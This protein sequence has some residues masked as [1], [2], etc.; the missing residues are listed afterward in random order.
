[1]KLKVTSSYCRIHFQI[2]FFSFCLQLPKPAR[3]CYRL[4]FLFPTSF[5]SP[6]L[7]LMNS[8]IVSWK[9]ISKHLMTESIIIICPYLLQR[10]STGAYCWLT[11]PLTPG[12]KGSVTFSYHPVWVSTTT[13]STPLSNCAS[14]FLICLYQFTIIF[15]K[16][17]HIFTGNSLA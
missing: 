10:K 16:I 8:D 5:P 9:Q 4:F 17:N 3:F 1:M 13:C 11:A 7:G 15:L 6:G 12:A 14:L 2:D